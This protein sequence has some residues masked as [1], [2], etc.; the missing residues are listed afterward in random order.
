M[1]SNS[2][3]ST[4]SMARNV[5]KSAMPALTSSQNI[6]PPNAVCQE[7]LKAA[8][9]VLQT[10]EEA[11]V[12]VGGSELIPGLHL[13]NNLVNGSMNLVSNG[14]EKIHLWLRS[15][16][17]MGKKLLGIIQENPTKAVV[18]TGGV[19]L[20]V[21]FGVR[22]YKY[23]LVTIPPGGEQSL[24]PS[25]PAEEAAAAAAAS[26]AD[27][28]GEVP[29]AGV[30]STTPLI[31]ET[32]DFTEGIELQELNLMRCPITEAP[33]QDPVVAADGHTYERYAIEH[34]FRSGQTFVFSSI[35][36][37]SFFSSI[38][39]F[40]FPFLFPFSFSFLS[41]FLF[42][43]FPPSFVFSSFFPFLTFHFRISPMTAQPLTHTDLTPNFLVL[44]T[45]EQLLGQ[46]LPPSA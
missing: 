41:L 33:F 9:E 34:W 10:A 11:M 43:F 12:P 29:S 42:L 19:L 3:A 17:E 23:Y 24:L 45:Q 39:L 4:L 14:L 37:L 18:V 1:A 25:A 40:L 21:A 13:L 44:Q 20:V 35:L 32:V 46:L 28:V 31:G 38:P 27:P 2:A 16:G 7:T 36:F 8:R 6:P 5:L 15:A 26:P 22:Q 30:G